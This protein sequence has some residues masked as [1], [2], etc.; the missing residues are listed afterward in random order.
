ML[1]ILGANAQSNAVRSLPP[2]ISRGTKRT[3]SVTDRSLYQLSSD[4]TTDTGKTMKLG[5]LRGQPQVV[6]MFFTTCQ[7]SCPMLVQEMRRLAG[8]LPASARKRVGFLLITFDAERDT[9]AVL[10][11]YRANLK[12][13]DKQWTILHGRPE[14]VQEL[15]L[16]LNVKYRQ[17]ANSQFSHSNVITLLNA[18]GEISFQ[19]IGLDNSGDQLAARLAKLLKP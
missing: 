13:A 14:D 7:S 4:W 12:I 15:A 11:A 16:V 6:A 3:D 18:E 9:P 1:A 17:G 19:Q 5:A 10:H 8:S 2:V